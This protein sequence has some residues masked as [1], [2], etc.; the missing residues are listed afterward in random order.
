MS[1]LLRV[2]PSIA[3]GVAGQDIN[4]RMEQVEQV[5]AREVKKRKTM[6]KR[7]FRTVTSWAEAGQE[8]IDMATAI[9]PN[10]SRD[11]P[12]KHLALPPAFDTTFIEEWQDAAT[13]QELQVC[14]GGGVVEDLGR[15][16]V[17]EL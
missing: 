12:A 17:V 3:L 6:L 2:S 10:D 13:E 14:Y 5:L 16:A 8:A 1:D 15:G 9:H 4:R 7:T 11:F